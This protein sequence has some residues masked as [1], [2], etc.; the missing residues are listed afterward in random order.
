MPAK[1]ERTSCY[2]PAGAVLLILILVTATG[3]L[4]STPATPP[5]APAPVLP[6]QE[7]YAPGEITRLHAAALEK[8]NNSLNG[9]AA[10]PPGQR[11]FDNTVL[12]F[13]RIESDYADSAAP[14][15]F[16][17]YVNPDPALAAE[18]MKAAETAGVFDTMVFTRR[19]LYDAMKDQVPRTPEET[20]LSN[21][22]LQAFL[23]NGLGLPDDR[24][25]RVRAMKTNLSVLESQYS[26]NLNQDNSTVIFTAAELDGVP[27]A[28]LATFTPVSPGSYSV[29]TKYVDYLAVMTYANSSETRKKMSAAYLN[30]Q[31]GP[32]TA[33][34]EQAIV[35]RGQIARESGYRTWADYQLHGRMAGN[36]STVMTFLYALKEP[37]R[38][39]NR[40][41][42]AGLLRT[43]KDLDPAATEVNPWDVAYLE[44]IQRNHEYAYNVEEVREYFPLDTVLS[45]LFSLFGPLFGIRFDEVKDTPV[46]S[47]D[48][49]VFRVGN[50]TDNQTIAYL[51]YDFYPREG[52]YNG[53]AAT[54]ITNGRM[55]NGSYTIPVA[56]VMANFPRP[57]SDRPSLLTMDD[58]TTLFHETGHALHGVLTRAPYGTLSG[59][60]VQPDFIETPSQTLEE[61]VWDPQVLESLSG[62]YTNTSE[63]I[64]PAL[65]KKVIAARKVGT[66]SYY[67]S[68]LAYALE[69][70][71]FHTA[72]GPVNTT[73]VWLQTY[74][75][76]RG[77]EPLAGTHQPASFGHLM[78]G[79]DAG[80][81]GYLWSK[82]YALNINDKFRQDGMTNR[83]TG[84]KYRQEILAPGFMQ[85]GNVLLKNFLGRDPGVE[86][87]Y[88]YL[89][90]NVSAAA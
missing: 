18:G 74:R 17:G 87:L 14:L 58:M 27:A 3:C 25:S 73:E 4:E 49:R 57:T 42:I 32:N 48:V 89:G 69:D 84:M 90:L 16:M 38:E 44:N 56:L 63:K 6:F 64:P 24:L 81:Y 46:W 85:D 78:G 11:T 23:D 77:M 30:I 82:V 68:Q 51:Y 1:P 67:S 34:L 39:K 72:D 33:L 12:A 19:D 54:V 40:D 29:T 61:W 37:L 66:G 70:M 13:D 43:K 76:I 79:Y 53:A 47:P 59:L 80:Y 9:I 7:H 26:A 86:P 83:T 35:L 71:R 52:K 62:R 10:I 15:I 20:R 8:A 22:T 5:A 28:S 75:E 65:L 88:Q 2:F 45:G 21:V 55:M 36:A 60:S 50:L 41:E 31:A